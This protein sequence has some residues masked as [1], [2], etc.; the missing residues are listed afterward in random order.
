MRTSEEIKARLQHGAQQIRE[1]LQLLAASSDC[2]QTTFEE[3]RVCHDRANLI[4]PVISELS[5]QIQT[6]TEDMDRVYSLRNDE[7][8]LYLKQENKNLKRELAALQ[9]A[10]RHETEEHQAHLTNSVKSNEELVQRIQSLERF[11][12]LLKTKIN[13]MKEQYDGAIIDLAD[14]RDTIACLRVTVKSLQS[15][16]GKHHRGIN[17]SSTQC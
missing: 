10:L 15:T 17:L 2:I 14:Q 9:Q 8:D 3:I 12:H 7:S 13:E 6:L 5:H 4:D 16:P 1:V 11:N